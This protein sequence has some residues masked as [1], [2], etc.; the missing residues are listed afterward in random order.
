VMALFLDSIADLLSQY[1]LQSGPAPCQ[2]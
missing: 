1:V 2:P